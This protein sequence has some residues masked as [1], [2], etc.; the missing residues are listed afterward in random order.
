M[1]VDTALDYLRQLAPDAQHDPEL[2][3]DLGNAY[4]RVARVQGV[5]IG[6]TLGQVD[7]AETSLRAAA[8]LIEPVLLAQPAN[9]TALLRSAQISQ[10][11]SGLA[12]LALRDEET[13]RFGRVAIERMDKLISLGK[14]SGP[15]AQILAVTYQN[16][17]VS[18]LGL[19]Q[20]EESV[21]N[22]RR[23]VDL[24]RDAGLESLVGAGLSVL[25]LTLRTQGNLDE[26]LQ[27][28]DEAARRL[29]V[30]AGINDL[31][32]TNNFI[33]A[34]SRK[35]A[36]LGDPEGISLDR[37]TE[38]AAVL[39]RAFQIAEDIA[40]R[41]PND[42]MPRSRLATAGI[43][44]GNVVQQSDPRRALAT[45]D[46]TLMRLAEVKKN[47]KA[48]REEIIALARSTYPL[49]RLGRGQ[50]ARQRLDAAVAR[51]REIGFYPV[52]QIEL[53]SEAEI[54]LRALGDF[55]ASSGGYR[56]SIEIYEDL[57]QRVKAYK[58]KEELLLLNAVRLS[59]IYAAMSSYYRK[60]GQPD[61]AVA[62]ES[63]RLELWRHWSHKLSANAFV[64]RQL[65]A[66]QPSK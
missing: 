60:A 9:R 43:R 59:N 6:S 21:R 5:P 27:A 41:D 42:Y 25:S 30:P 38:A 52:D 55:E 64:Q 40:R 23:A 46:H 15:E 61:D 47:V 28:I 4:M 18:Q 1:I 7:K 65:D 29:E 48:R 66:A 32:R 16:V 54:T 17:A 45:Y 2:A 49:A 36:I 31:G 11:R 33:T 24:A 37:T 13:L 26:A 51:L 20:I 19:D 34:L 8:S 58:P 57:L 62:I 56:R 63:R 12:A 14:P 39:E 35:G 22:A 53:G 44:L 10:D 3:L 50:D